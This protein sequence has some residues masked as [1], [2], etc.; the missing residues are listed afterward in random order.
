MARRRAAPADHRAELALLFF[1]VD[2]GPAA[3]Q[4]APSAHDRIYAIDRF[5]AI[6]G[7][8]I[9]RSRGVE[10]RRTGDSALALYGLDGERADAVGRALETAARID[11]RAA[12]LAERLARELSLR[13]EF[14]VGVDVGLVVVGTIGAQHA[15]RVSAIGPGVDAAERLRAAA[16]AAG[17]RHVV[18]KAAA[19][20][21]GL[22]VATFDWQPGLD[23]QADPTARWAAVVR[24]STGEPSEQ[25]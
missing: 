5:D 25:A 14:S 7:R 8:E 3:A 12:R 15:R 1:E 11:T 2:I 17:A 16:L 19:V 20:A 9:E 10:C 23:D 6:V 21:A 18:S 13:A 4:A 24:A 22:E